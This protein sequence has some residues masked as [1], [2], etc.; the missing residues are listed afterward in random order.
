V[1]G[2]PKVSVEDRESLWREMDPLLAA[3]D[4]ADAREREAEIEVKR[5]TP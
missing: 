1:C 5:Y 2:F 4:I 3:V